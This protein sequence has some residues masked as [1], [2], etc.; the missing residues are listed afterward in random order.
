MKFKYYFAKDFATC[1]NHEIPT[2]KTHYYRIRKDD[3]IEAIKRVA[4]S[5]GCKIKATDI[6]RGEV[7]FDHMQY[8][9]S[10]TIT[11]VSFTETA[12]DLNV[13][14]YNILPTAKGKKI[15][16]EYYMA[17]DKALDGKRK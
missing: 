3:A 7:V 4:L 5:F 17:I 13:F 12:I 9:A 15:I 11:G 10:A 6:E 14:T 2:L 16:E 8:S 1:D